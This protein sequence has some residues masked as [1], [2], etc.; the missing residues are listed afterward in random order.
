MSISGRIKEMIKVSGYSVFLEEIDTILIQHP[1]VAEVATIGV[2]HPFRGEE[3][4]SFVVLADGLNGDVSKEDIIGYCKG[5][6][7][8][9][10]Y[11]RQIEFIDELPKSGAGKVLRRVLA[12]KYRH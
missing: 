12:E 8:A 10:K 11:P 2:P 1:A 7:A 6:M 4:K 9:Y 3:A 5:K